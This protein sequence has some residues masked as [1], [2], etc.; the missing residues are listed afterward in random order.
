ME[1]KMCQMYYEYEKKKIPKE[2]KCSKTKEK[3]HHFIW[4]PFI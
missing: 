1:A 4:E 2:Q 3:G